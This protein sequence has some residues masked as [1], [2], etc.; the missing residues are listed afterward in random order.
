[1]SVL[2]YSYS[3]LTSFE[4]CPKKHYEERIA[5]SVVRTEHKAATDGTTAH[6]MA[7]DYI[8]SATPFEHKYK[9]H[10]L[11]VIHELNTLRLEVARSLF[12]QRT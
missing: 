6:K 10:I 9:P 4:S 7:E 2:P 3:S 12:P 5:K 8:N 1:M 11:K